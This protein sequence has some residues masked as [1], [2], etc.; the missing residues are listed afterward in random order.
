[1]TKNLDMKGKGLAILISALAVAAS[2]QAVFAQNASIPNVPLTDIVSRVGGIFFWVIAA[3]AFFCFMYAAYNFITAGA[4]SNKAQAARS[5]LVYGAIGLVVAIAAWG[6]V[7]FIT[8][9]FNIT[10]PLG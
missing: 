6:I 10:N 4:D 3:A 9:T 8:G 7:G 2:T 1:M 5:W